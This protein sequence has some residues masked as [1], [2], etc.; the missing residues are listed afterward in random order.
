MPP[1][2]TLTLF[3]TIHLLLTSN[4][5]PRVGWGGGSSVLNQDSLLSCKNQAGPGD[6]PLIRQVGS[7]GQ[8][9]EVV[10]QGS[11]PARPSLV[12]HAPAPPQGRVGAQPHP[13]WTWAGGIGSPGFSVGRG[14]DVP[15]RVLS[16]VPACPSVT[17][18]TDP[19]NGTEFPF[20]VALR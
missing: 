10:S 12:P 9:T 3:P 20:E 13:S 16:W 18:Q 8:W 15:C 1:L 4:C 11:E 6:H 19:Q 14:E 5:R 2:H 7:R 17:T